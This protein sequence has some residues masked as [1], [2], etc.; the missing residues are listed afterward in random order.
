MLSAAM[1][2][3]G[4]EIPTRRSLLSRLKNC[5]DHA[6]WRVFFY[7]YWKIIYNAAIRAGLTAAE[8]EDVVQ[9]TVICVSRK[10]PEFI[11][12]PKKGSFKG[13]LLQLTTWR[14]RDH[15]RNRLPIHPLPE[16]TQTH[17]TTRL[18]ERVPDPAPQ[19]EAAWDAEWE[20]NLLEAALKRV[21]QKVDPKHYQ[22]FDLYVRKKWPVSKIAHDLKINAAA[23]YLAR[24]RVGRVLQK[25]LLAI[26]SHP[27]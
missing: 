16:Q 13:W 22:I 8:A 19:F 5:E 18:L 23:V 11:Y 9:E 25:E 20:D 15:Y 7:T 26:K 12:D 6:S 1:V 27:I 2:Y 14:I 24:H 10:V 21:K 4:D 17:R 3:P